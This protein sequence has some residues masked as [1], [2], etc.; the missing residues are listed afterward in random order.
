MQ[1]GLTTNDSARLDDD[2]LRDTDRGLDAEAVHKD[3]ALPVEG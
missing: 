2:Y 3:I 1:A